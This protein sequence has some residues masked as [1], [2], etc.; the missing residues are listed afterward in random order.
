[1]STK[2]V[3]FVEPS[4]SPSNIFAKFMS[5]PLLGP[6]YLATIAKQA[7]YDTT[8]LNENVLGRQVTADELE[9]ADILCLSCITTTVTRG[10]QIAHQYREV[11]KSHQGNSRVIIGGIHAS[12]MPDDVCADFDQVVTGEAESVFLDILAGRAM[13]KIVQ[14]KRT[15]NLDDL[16]VPDYSL[17]KE[18]KGNITPVMTSRGCPFHCNF[19]SVTEM[20][21]RGYR[22]QSPERVIK[23]ILP[24]KKGTVFFIDDHFAANP[25]RTDR[26]LDLIMESEF[27]QRWTAQVRTE[28]TK[29]PELVAKM[30]KAG[31]KIVYVGFESIVPQTL[32]DMHKS[33]TVA[34]IERSIKVFRDH[35]IL[36]HGM[37]MLGNDADTPDV[38][39]ATSDFCL[40]NQLDFVQYAILC[41]LP[42]TQVFAQFEREGRLLHR[43]W[44]HYDA[45]HA[46]FQPKHMTPHEL[47]EGMVNCFR[48]FYTYAHAFND[49]ANAVL[50]AVSSLAKKMTRAN[51]YFPSL[52]PSV[53]KLAGHKI[54]QNWIRGNRNYLEY[55]KGS[56]GHSR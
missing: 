7:G 35:G 34:D 23:E 22:T 13:D 11:R 14:G 27:S 26:I 52:F 49:A 56:T 41:P 39:E 31:C 43:N 8:I 4:G 48:D 50:G 32:E 9:C 20:F 42:G 15:E 12:M 51:A 40:K 28:V 29:K 47:Q 2:K 46:V 55:L 3:V 36:V 18:W 38:F 17:I 1:M 21:G 16:P 33:Q 10:K 19:C 45:L 53:M 6:V 30:R 44:E 37:F 24:V 5:I 54:V 25:K